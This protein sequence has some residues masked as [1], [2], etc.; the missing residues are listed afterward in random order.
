MSTHSMY[1]KAQAV[2]GGERARTQLARSWAHS[3]GVGIVA[4][5][6]DLNL[7]YANQAVLLRSVRIQ[8]DGYPHLLM[9]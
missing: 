9:A 2:V 7:H 6:H 4:V 3:R 1:L 8:T 5:L